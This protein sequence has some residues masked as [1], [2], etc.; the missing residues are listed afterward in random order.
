[1]AEA[2][3][4][5]GARQHNL[6]GV[7]LDVPKG[8][9][10][11][12]E[13]HFDGKKVLFSMRRDIADDY[14]LYEMSIVPL[15]AGG[16]A[17]KQLT[18]AKRVSDIQPVYMPD[19]K[20]VFSSTRDPKYIPC[21]RHLM[22]NLFTMNGDGTNIRQIGYNT[23]FEGRAS[24]MPDG[25]ILY[26]RWEYVDKHFASAYG[27]W[28]ANPDGTNHALYYGGYG[29]QPGPVVDARIVPGSRRFVAVFGAVH[30]TVPQTRQLIDRQRLQVA[31]GLDA[32]EEGQIHGLWS[33]F[34]SLNA[35]L[36]WCGRPCRRRGRAAA[37]P[38]PRAARARRGPPPGG[39]ARRP[40]SA[41]SRTRRGR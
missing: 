37:R 33:S 1:M 19:G 20:I 31:R 12:L 18:F 23:Q 15:G 38:A 13:V 21:Q 8:I 30:G 39:G 9:A 36:T 27:L 41:R 35:T 7:D 22:A 4:I 26:T 11:D 5:R 17:A 25:R 14:H 3:T 32:G 16:G 34:A 29:W 40:G 28:T 24:L 2:I 10:R 6:K